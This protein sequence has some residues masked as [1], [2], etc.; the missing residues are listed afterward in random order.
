MVNNVG[1]YS[2]CNYSN[3]VTGDVSFIGVEKYGAE[4]YL[5]LLIEQEYEVKWFQSYQ[6][7]KWQVIF[8]QIHVTGNF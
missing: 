2:I 7:N 1:T 3:D 8:F 4:I 5:L 6:S